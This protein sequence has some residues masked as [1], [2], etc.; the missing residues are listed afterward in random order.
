MLVIALEEDGKVAHHPTDAAEQRPLK[1]IDAGVAERARG[2]QDGVRSGWDGMGA[3]GA[4]AVNLMS[5]RVW[6]RC[7][8]TSFRNRTHVVGR[9]ML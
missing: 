3:H 1:H 7:H 4:A 6:G 2:M 8:S 9:L 5:R